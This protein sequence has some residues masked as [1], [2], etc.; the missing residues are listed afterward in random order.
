MTFHL[1]VFSMGFLNLAVPAF[2]AWS[3]SVVGGCSVHCRMSSSIPGLHPLGMLPQS[4]SK[5]KKCLL[6]L[7]NIPWG[8]KSRLM[9]SHCMLFPL[10]GSLSPCQ[11]VNSYSCVRTQFRSCLLFEA[12]WILWAEYKVRQVRHLPPSQNLRACQRTPESR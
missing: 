11:L 1:F 10:L 9:E 6:S 2:G 8:T 5:F 3:F 12:L 7:P 4:K